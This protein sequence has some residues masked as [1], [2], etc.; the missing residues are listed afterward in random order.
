[1][2]KIV[3][4]VRIISNAIDEIL[5]FFAKLRG[6]LAFENW[7]AFTEMANNRIVKSTENVTKTM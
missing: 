2:H 6:F 4:S 1:M 7:F 3:Q 5:K